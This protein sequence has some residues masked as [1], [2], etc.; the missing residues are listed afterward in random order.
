M[1]DFI[2]KDK[3]NK[4]LLVLK[5]ILAVLVCYALY[6]G[7]THLGNH[8]NK[9]MFKSSDAMATKDFPKHHRGDRA[10]EGVLS[11][12]EPIFFTLN[13]PKSK[14]KKPFGMGMS[15]HGDKKK[16]PTKK[17]WLVHGTD[18]QYTKSVPPMDLETFYYDT[19]QTLREMQVNAARGK[20]NYSFETQKSGYYNLFAKNETLN[21]DTLYY[22]VAK[23]EYLHGSHGGEDRYTD[24]VKNK[25]QTDKSDIDLILLKNKDED[26]F[27]YKHS[28]GD[29]LQFQALLHNKPLA[30]ANITVKMES[31]WSKRVKTDA[32]GIAKFQ[33]IRDYFPESGEFDKRHKEEL[34]LTLRYQSDEVGKKGDKEY[35]KINYILTYPVSFYPANSDYE[36][37]GYALML[38]TLTLLIAGIVVYRFRKNRTKP[39]RE[40][41]YEE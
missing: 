13:D 36:S 18:L 3:N 7:F 15:S 35:A 40:L 8:K 37:Y 19:N 33:I 31:G 23:M 16:I 11:D 2:K 25:V 28:M 10:K 41:R 17:I 21:D 5:S 12:N 29:E 32:N 20:S 14:G 38:I 24:S 9:T 30:N 1:V 6:F 4:F 34:L 39:F 26:S 22:K 27:F